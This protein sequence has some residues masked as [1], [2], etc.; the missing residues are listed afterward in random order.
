[1][2]HALVPYDDFCS[3]N[4]VPHARA[5]PQCAVRAFGRPIMTTANSPVMHA[6]S[7]PVAPFKPTLRQCVC[8]AAIVLLPYAAMTGIL[9]LNG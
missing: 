6:A 3:K 5:L 4:H 1:M 9:L 2:S 7:T 8:A